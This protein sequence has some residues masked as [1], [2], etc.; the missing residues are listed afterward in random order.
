MPKTMKIFQMN[1][2]PEEPYF[3]V[4]ALFLSE[5]SDMMSTVGLRE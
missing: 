1:K 2:G 4:T 3:Q 5:I